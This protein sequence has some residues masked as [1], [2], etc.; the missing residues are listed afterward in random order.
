MKHID[1]RAIP[2]T[3][4]QHRF[5]M[6]PGDWRPTESE[7]G[8]VAL[9]GPLTLDADIQ[10]AGKNIVLKGHLQGVVQVRCDRCLG[11]FERNVDTAFSVFLSLPGDSDA[12]AELELEEEDLDVEFPS[13]EELDIHEL[14][15]EQVLLEQPIKRLCSEG[16]KG[17]CTRCGKNLN[18]GACECSTESGHPAFQKLKE[19]KI[20]GAQD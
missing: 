12:E 10:R 9:A 8:V 2:E 6:E 1:L 14:I 18:E 20:K 3:G 7:E 4:Q 15:R 11:V 17:L 19:L 16:C 5:R 13:G